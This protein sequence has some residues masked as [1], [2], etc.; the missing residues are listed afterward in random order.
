MQQ[1]I[2][3]LVGTSV[4]TSVLLVGGTAFAEATAPTALGQSQRDG[5]KMM[6]RTPG[7][8]GTV[9]AISGSTITITSK[10]PQFGKKPGTTATAG[11][12][13]TYTINAGSAIVTKNNV[14]S[15]L[16]SI[17]VGDVIAAEGTISG[18]TVT[19]T[20]IRDGIPTGKG[21]EGFGAGHA[22]STTAQAV[23]QGNGQPVIGGAV[24][25]ITGNTLTVTNKSNVTYTV[26][27]T[28]AKF[29]KPGIASASVANI[30]VGDNVIVQGAVNGNAVTATSVI[31]QGVVPTTT[32]ATSNPP[33]VAGSA[34]TPR[35][36]FF[37]SIGG[38]F[39][40]LFGFF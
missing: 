21:G 6:P 12:V 10:A 38:F 39:H 37:E 11:T 17:T 25:A 28:S 2:G 9:T 4:L 8:F 36:G 13:T 35:T 14:A 29:V 34:V 7:V 32:N 33:T 16:S 19:A 20:T 18:T 3:L 24:T 26:D 27:V 40:K 1:K 23:I 5:V 30:T 31:D 15:S 22:S